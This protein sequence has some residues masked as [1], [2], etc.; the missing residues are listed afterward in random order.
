MVC[1]SQTRPGWERQMCLHYDHVD[2]KILMVWG[3]F[4]G[5]TDLHK[6]ARGTMSAFGNGDEI[7][8]PIGSVCGIMPD[9]CVWTVSTVLNDTALF[10][11]TGRPHPYIHKSESIPAPLGHRATF[12]QQPPPCCTTGCPGAEWCPNPG[13]RG[14]SC[15]TICYLIR[16]N[17]DVAGTA[18]RSDAEPPLCAQ[19]SHRGLSHL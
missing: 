11:M 7:L 12:H 4:D 15:E 6:L 1:I 13:Q 9:L 19:E 10:L 14:Y 2:S 3:F 5:C 8:R 18:S 16:I 17:P